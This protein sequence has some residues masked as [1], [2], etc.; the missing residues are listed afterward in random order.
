MLPVESGS[1]H[2]QLRPIA[3]PTIQQNRRD[4]H[5]KPL[6]QE[7][8]PCQNIYVGKLIVGLVFGTL[9]YV[10]RL[11]NYL[12]LSAQLGHRAVPKI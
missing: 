9:T 11:P 3:H 2:S 7:S 4:I 12:F 1:S 6:V 10:K 5:V 8:G